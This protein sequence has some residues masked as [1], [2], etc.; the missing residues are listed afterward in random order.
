MHEARTR[1]APPLVAALIVVAGCGGPAA[2]TAAPIVT[3]SPLSSAPPSAG[4]AT[5]MHAWPGG[6]TARVIGVEKLDPSL[7]NSQDPANILVKLTVTLTNTGQAAALAY[8]RFLWQLLTGPNRVEAHDDEGN[9]FTGGKLT[10]PVPEQLGAGQTLT[11]FDSWDVPADQV[12]TLA[13]RV[14]LGG[15]VTPWT[16]TDVQTLLK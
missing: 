10:S 4:P 2:K 7:G 13:V 11:L 12:A 3:S 1:R 8:N 16:F 14:D 5:A 9:Q 15:T 6:L